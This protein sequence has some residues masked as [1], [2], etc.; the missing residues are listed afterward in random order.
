MQINISTRVSVII[1]IIIIIII[2]KTS[3]SQV[4]TSNELRDGSQPPNPSFMAIL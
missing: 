2:H 4:S 1:I 3:K